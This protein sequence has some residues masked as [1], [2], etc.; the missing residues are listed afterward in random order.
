MPLPWYL[1]TST[2]SNTMNYCAPTKFQVRAFK[3]GCILH[4]YTGKNV[5]DKRGPMFGHLL[6]RVMSNTV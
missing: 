2:H 4:N 5:I 6:R 3:Y 1:Y